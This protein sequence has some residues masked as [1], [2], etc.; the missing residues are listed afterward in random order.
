MDRIS[1][2]EQ[3]H[4]WMEACAPCNKIFLDAGEFTDLN[5]N[6]VVD[7]IRGWRKGWRKGWRP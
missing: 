3:A 5:Y 4:V 2:P 7:R 1:D 6:N